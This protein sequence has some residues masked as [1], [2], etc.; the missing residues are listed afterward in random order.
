MTMSSNCRFVPSNSAKT[1]SEP[2]VLHGRG[3][4]GKRLPLGVARDAYANQR[5]LFGAALSQNRHGAESFIIDTCDEV[6]VTRA[7]L[8]PQL[9]YL[10]FTDT[11]SSNST[12]VGAER[13]VNAL[14]AV[15]GLPGSQVQLGNSRFAGEL[16]AAAKRCELS[17]FDPAGRA[18][19]DSCGQL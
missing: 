18:H 14:P 10:H 13:S 11:H 15:A 8:F 9:S 1:P 17:Q 7:V 6:D 5:L 3:K 19:P 16:D 12:L 2:F 4:S